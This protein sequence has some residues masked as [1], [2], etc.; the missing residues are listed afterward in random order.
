MSHERARGLSDVFSKDRLR[1]GVDRSGVMCMV[2]YQ[3]LYEEIDELEKMLFAQILSCDDEEITD[4]LIRGNSFVMVAL[5]RAFEKAP[6]EIKLIL[7]KNG[8]M[9]VNDAA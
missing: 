6:D 2:D 4:L 9:R 7:T 8:R 1:R 3:V 5:S